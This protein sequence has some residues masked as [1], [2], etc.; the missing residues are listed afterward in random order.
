MLKNTKPEEEK[1]T[2]AENRKN[3]SDINFFL[4]K[5]LENK[6]ECPGSLPGN[7]ISGT[8]YFLLLH[9]GF[10]GEGAPGVPKLEIPMIHPQS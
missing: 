3:N 4:T 5:C 10:L 9:Q 8:T 7:L 1:D 6:G 2:L